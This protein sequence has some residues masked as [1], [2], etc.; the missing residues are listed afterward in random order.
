MKTNKNYTLLSLIIL[1]VF[2]GVLLNLAGCSNSGPELTAGDLTATTD[3]IIILIIEKTQAFEAEIEV[4]L[5]EMAPTMTNTPPP[6]LTLSD[7]LIPSITPTEFLDPWV[8]Q[9]ECRNNPGRCVK[10]RFDNRQ[11]SYWVY[12]TLTHVDSDVSKKFSVAPLVYEDITLIAGDYQAI[13]SSTCKGEFV[14]FFR[15]AWLGAERGG[16]R[17]AEPR[18]EFWY[19]LDGEIIF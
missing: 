6:S 8:L 10:Y 12:I 2:F 7:T 14:S 15:N 9:E 18:P 19:V 3:K 11:N 16:L 4:M 1:L 5:T 17:C 13:Y